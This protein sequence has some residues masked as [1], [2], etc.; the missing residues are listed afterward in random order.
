M[1]IKE[2]VEKLR[3]LMIKNGIDAYIVPSSDAHQSE[4][5]SE[6][7]KSRKWISGFT[8]S[9]G[10][11][12]ITLDDAGLWTDGR[13]YIQAAKQLQD[14]GIRLFKGAEPGVPSYIQWLKEVLKEGSTVGFDGN[15]ISVVTVR[16]MEKE[17]KNKNIVLKS[18]KDLIGE[19]WDDRP[20][21]PDGK[22]FIY[23]VKYAGKS[24]T[25]KINEVR[26]YMKEKNANY[27][28]LTSLDD[29]AWLLNIRGTDVPHNPVI[30]SN[31]V[32]TMEKTYLFISPS[33]VS[34]DVRE[35]LENENVIV[36]DYD[37]IE[38]FLKTLT[39]K[40][41]VI[42]DATK[43]NI[44]LYKAMDK[45]V[46]KIHEL[47]ITTDLK[48]I[49][50]EVEVENLKNCQVK[51]GVA[52]VKFIKWLKESVDK[53]EITE[54]LAEEKIRSL[55]EE[56]ELFSDISFETI[57]AYKDHAAMMH[58]KATEE[59]NCVLK[60]EGMLLVDSGGQYFD[61]TTD[62]TRT[63]VLGKLTEEEKKHFTL[64]LKSNIAL[65]TLKFL[66]GS[67]GSN[68][69]VIARKPIWEYGIDYKCGT[70]HGVGFFLNIHEGP[71]RFSPVPNN[72]VLKKGM[73]ITNE[74]GIYMEGKYGIRTENMMLVVEKEKTEFGQFM[75]FEY[76]TYCPID[77]DG[78]D[79]EMLTMEEVK[80]LN[81]YHKDV[82][83]KLSPYLNEEEKEFLK[84]ETREI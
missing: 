42:Y 62:I 61:G 20:Q 40:D 21:I 75:K 50:N 51:D 60:P 25:E 17:F 80:W 22:I 27:Y 13:Y 35:E 55:R 10:T 6:H 36:K 15:V 52:M 9:A 56:Q 30:V 32:I 47:N 33:K 57:A 28:L 11:C 23:D 64:V 70:G 48:G 66:Y 73:T 41:I 71:Q 16:D 65:N 83:E 68:L 43:T 69:D 59:T 82:Y 54:L 44:R 76:I 58:Y 26:K 45:N 8:G 29:I 18:H 4:Y 19:L 31:A 77:L 3:Q 67:T 79:K 39:E 5:V 24:R 46:E 2:R 14:S 37:E 63:I 34:S 12:V 72:A 78:I 84:Q 1:M 74:P 7:W 53:E 49:K 81:N 38:K